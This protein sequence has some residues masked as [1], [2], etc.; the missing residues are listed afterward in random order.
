MLRQPSLQVRST[1]VFIFVIL[2]G[3]PTLEAASSVERVLPSSPAGFITLQA[4]PDSGLTAWAVEEQLPASVT[5][6]DI[7]DGGRYDPFT[8]KV[9]WG[10][11]TDVT[12]RDL[13]YRIAAGP[14]EVVLSG[15]ASWDGGAPATTTGGTTLLVGSDGGFRDWLIALY[16]D[17]IIG[18]PE[19][20]PHYDGDDDGNP[21]LAEYYFGLDPAIKDAVNFRLQPEP[22]SLGLRLVRRQSAGDLPTTLWF[23]SNLSDWSTLDPGPPLQLSTEGDLETIQYDFGDLTEPAFIRLQLGD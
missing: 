20:D 14:G 15:R 23:S 5:P 19:A 3:Q 10:P 1:C 11:Y 12:D 21:L 17:A 13:Q 4:R 18:T 6:L 9:K 8:N 7:S 2:S 22:G 16:G